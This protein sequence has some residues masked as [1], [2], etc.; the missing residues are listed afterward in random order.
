MPGT[1]PC[2]AGRRATL[3]SAAAVYSRGL[4]EP[5]MS[6]A[7]VALLSMAGLVL[8]AACAA[9]ATPSEAEIA[10][11]I[12][13]AVE[14][15]VDALA[16]SVPPSTLPPAVTSAPTQ[17][18]TDP[19][20]PPTATSTLS[21]TESLPPAPARPMISVSRTTNCRAGPGRAYR[22]LSSLRPGGVGQGTGRSRVGGYWE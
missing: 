20:Q 10:Q 9:P 2:I 3:S 14:G 13:A 16:S 4:L 1:Q 19:A 6:A 8:L 18:A 7:R 11:R 22:L 21:P 17:P 12:D 15:T 5:G